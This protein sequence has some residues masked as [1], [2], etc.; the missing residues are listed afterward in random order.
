MLEFTLPQQLNNLAIHY[1]L[2]FARH[3]NCN[4][5]KRGH[6]PFKKVQF[7]NRLAV[8]VTAVDALLC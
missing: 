1:A 6:L 4:L 5:S 8:V 7:M 3:L 2:Y